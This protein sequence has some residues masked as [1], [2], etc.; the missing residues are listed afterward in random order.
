VRSEIV[1]AYIGV[2]LLGASLISVGLLVSSLTDNPVSAA[3][4]TFGAILFIWAL[5][6]LVQALP[7]DRAAGLVFLCLLSLLAALFVYTT[8][9]N[10]W[11]TLAVGAVT[12][13]ATGI[14]YGL[15]PSV[16][17]GLMV[18]ILLW[19]SLVARYGNFGRGVL[20]VGQVLYYISFSATFIFLTVR[21]IDKRRWA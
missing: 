13:G 2:F 4:L 21:V 14:V 19:F 10:W 20:A 7:R 18:R 8:T 9:R 6:W 5:D 3:L 1:C 16:F 15:Q 12:L 17:D 11:I